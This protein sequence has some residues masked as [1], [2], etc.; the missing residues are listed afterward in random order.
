MRTYTKNRRRLQLGVESLEG[1][2]LLSTGSVMDQVVPPVRAAP[3]GAQETAAFSGTLTGSYSNV[4]VP[5]FANTLSYATSGT[6]S[7]V[8]STRLRGTLFGRL[9]A[10]TGRLV[11]QLVMHNNGGS[12]IVNVFRSAM[13]GTY[14]YKVARVRGSDT[15]FEGERD[16]L[17]ISQTP[18]FSVPYYTAGQA[19]M[20][21]TPG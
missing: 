5:G 11:G 3:I 15:A 20:T 17:M 19:T 6:L 4:H 7:G 13:P 21:F 8:G 2:I 16:T 12:M 10:P 9:G 14:S 1:K 18:T